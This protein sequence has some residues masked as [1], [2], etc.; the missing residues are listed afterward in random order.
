MITSFIM[1]STPEPRRTRARTDGIRVPAIVAASG[2]DA[3]RQFLNFFIASIRNRHT[4]R[5]YARQA[6]Q[7]L[8][9]CDARGC[10][11]LPSITT[12]HVSAYIEQLTRS[13]LET[14]SVKQALSSLRML[15]SWLVVHQVVPQNPAAVVRGPRHSVSEGSTP[16]LEAP[17]VS[18]IIEAIPIESLVGLRDRAL[19]GLMAYTFARIGAAVAMNVKDFFPQGTGY[20]VRL[21]EKGGRRKQIAC[22]HLLEEYLVA[23]IAAAYLADHTPLFRTARGKTGQLTLNRIDQSAAWRMLQRRARA[24]GVDARLCNHTWRASGITTFLA[25]GGALE[26]AQ[27]MAGHA[28][29]RTTKLYDRRRQMVTRSE[30]ERIRYERKLA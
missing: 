1:N 6:F 17:D 11:E 3:A 4:R 2:E 23:Y 16:A 12:A 19:I 28:D 7:F 14:A 9:W 13:E 21:R 25:N 22:H 27:Y 5:A 24:A 18:R 20:M 29:P 10:R 30:V 15:F 26:M 8:A